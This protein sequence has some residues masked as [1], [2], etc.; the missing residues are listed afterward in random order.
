M[1]NDQTMDKGTAATV[2][3]TSH[4]VPYGNLAYDSTDATP[5]R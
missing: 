3:S 2:A 4:L 5:T 1:A